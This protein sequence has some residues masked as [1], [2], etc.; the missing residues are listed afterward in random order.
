MKRCKVCV[1]PE[2]FPGIKFDDEGVCNFCAS[3]KGAENQEK[4]KLKYRQK[5]EDLLEQYKGKSSYDALMS[6]SG[7]KDST[8]VLML[9]KEEYGLN[10]L[11]LTF[12]NGFLPEQTLSNIRRVCENVGIDLIIF[13]PSFDIM[14]KIF[15]KSSITNIFPEKTLA[16]ASTICNSCISFV[17]FGSLRFAVEKD[18]PLLAFGWSPGQIPVASS[19]MK[20]NPQMV[21]VT[22]KAAYDPL[23][24]IA[25]DKIKPFFLEQ[26]HFSDAYDFPYNVSPLAFLDYNE[27]EIYAKIDQIGWKAPKN[28]DANTTNCLLNSYANMI[29]RDR[30]GYHPYVFELAKLVR[31]GYMERS[32]ALEKLNEPE[33]LETIDLVKKKLEL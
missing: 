30:Y 9:L 23:Y 16:R 27:E 15:Q 18:I 19:I 3:F 22:Q 10:I 31:E 5:F 28:I 6:Y 33:I 12:D 29:H 14:K 8:Y 7:G 20:N 25:G 11:A 1:L 4:K 21:E 17:K 32:H 26:K 24:E 2:T 13:K